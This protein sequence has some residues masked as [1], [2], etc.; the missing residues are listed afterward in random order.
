MTRA[1]ERIRACSAQGRLKELVRYLS[2][3]MWACASFALFPSLVTA[4]WEDVKALIVQPG[5]R[6]A[7]AKH[8][9]GSQY[10][11]GSAVPRDYSEALIPVRDFFHNLL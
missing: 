11:T 9:L 4:Q 1:T 7:A 8:T 3:M 5:Q 10:K 2:P 6:V